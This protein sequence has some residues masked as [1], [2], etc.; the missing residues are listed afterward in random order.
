ME[1]SAPQTIER[2]LLNPPYKAGHI[3]DVHPI[4]IDST[5][6]SQNVQVTPPDLRSPGEANLVHRYAS[7]DL[8]SSDARCV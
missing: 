7:I 3:G 8:R 5:F 2:L 6:G 4:P 1:D